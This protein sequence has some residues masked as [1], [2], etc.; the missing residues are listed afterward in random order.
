M[1]VMGKDIDNNVEYYNKNADSFFTGSVNA[2][3]AED[4]EAFLA[5]VP[6]SGKILDAGCGSG[7]VGL[8]DI[9]LFTDD[10]TDRDDRTLSLF[11]HLRPEMADQIEDTLQVGADDSIES[12][13]FHLVGHG[14][15]RDPGITDQNIDLSVL[16]DQIVKQSSA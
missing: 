5:Y 7:I 16:C 4:R 14:I 8:A 3:M 13:A 11:L 6:D 2:D 1:T 12:I 15:G 9:A 10:R